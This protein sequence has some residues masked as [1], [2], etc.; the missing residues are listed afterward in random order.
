M[1]EV[2]VQ[3]Q[4]LS[5]L[6]ANAAG[7]LPVPP[8]WMRSIDGFFWLLWHKGLKEFRKVAGFDEL[9]NQ[10]TR[11]RAQQDPKAAMPARQDH[12]CPSRC[13][14]DERSVLRC[15]RA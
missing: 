15:F 2:M 10:L 8:W 7:L 4:D 11:D 12:I 1:P 13:W 5:L 14:T 3:K 9:G 6:G